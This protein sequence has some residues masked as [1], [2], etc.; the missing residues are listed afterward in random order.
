MAVVEKPGKGGRSF[1][2][3]F[4]GLS[5]VLAAYRLWRGHQTASE[6]FTAVAAAFLLVAWLYPRLLDGPNRVWMKFARALGWVN[7]RILL[8]IFFFVIIT[9]YGAI[10]RLVGRDRLGRRWRAAPPTW[11]PAPPRLRDPKHFDHLY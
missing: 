5:A 3:A 7:S 11:V 10:Q 9:P 6:A 4:G 1:G 8:S 2:L